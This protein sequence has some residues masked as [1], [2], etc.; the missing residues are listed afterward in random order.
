MSIWPL[1][2]CH[3]LPSPSFRLIFIDL[4]MIGWL[5]ASLLCDKDELKKICDVILEGESCRHQNS[6]LRTL[7]NLRYIRVLMLRIL[8]MRVVQYSEVNYYRHHYACSTRKICYYRHELWKNWYKPSNLW[9]YGILR[10]WVKT[11]MW[12]QVDHSVPIKLR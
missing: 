10:V 12:S 8:C 3:P 4:A 11:V 7:I 1:M 5:L 9:K 6:H 2:T